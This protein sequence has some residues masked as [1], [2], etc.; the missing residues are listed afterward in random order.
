MSLTNWERLETLT[1]SQIECAAKEDQD[2]A[3]LTDDELKDFRRV[4]E[5][6]DANKI[7]AVPK[8]NTAMEEL[9]AACCSFN[10]GHTTY[11]VV[12]E[13]R[14]NIVYLMSRLQTYQC[15]V[16]EY[17]AS[18]SADPGTS[19]N[20]FRDELYKAVLESNVRGV[21]EYYE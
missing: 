18:I 3:W 10:H 7:A 19:M 16:R 11:D 6:S 2:S 17:G 1:P 9:Y 13:K 4:S 21:I 20:V 8:Y 15:K 14:N 5:T 12:K